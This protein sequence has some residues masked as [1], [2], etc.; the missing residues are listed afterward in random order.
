MPWRVDDRVRTIV[1]R[2]LADERVRWSSFLH[3][4]PLGSRHLAQACYGAKN[5]WD[6]VGFV[7]EIC[8]SQEGCAHH[9]TLLRCQLSNKS[10]LQLIQALWELD[11]PPYN[12]PLR[13]AITTVMRAD[14]REVL[15]AEE[16]AATRARDAE[17]APNPG[18]PRSSSS[19]RP[20][21]ISTS[22]TRSASRDGGPVGR[23]V[24]PTCQVIAYIYVPGHHNPLVVRAVGTPR[25]PV[26]EFVFGQPA[27][28]E[29]LG[30]DPK[31]RAK[32]KYLVWN[33]SI[34]GWASHP[35]PHQSLFLIPGERVLYKEEYVS[36]LPQLDY[37][38][39]QLLPTDRERGDPR[40]GPSI[41]NENTQRDRLATPPPTASLPGT[42][43]RPSE[44]HAL[45]GCPAADG[46]RQNEKVA[47]GSGLPGKLVPARKKA[48]YDPTSVIDL[49]LDESEEDYPEGRSRKVPSP[50][51]TSGTPPSL[52]LSEELPPQEKPL[53][54]GSPAGSS[55]A[56]QIARRTRIIDLTLDDSD[57]GN[58]SAGPQVVIDV[59]DCD[60]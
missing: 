55:S 51:S 60:G 7:L 46:T 16:R 54:C 58:T 23:P 10:R 52:S 25:D 49:T 31:S 44:L 13:R 53:G 48:R 56:R 3:P 9:K 34:D 8:L 29:A 19:V 26:V 36:F 37:Y 50:P 6:S 45:L 32:P 1:K 18:T 40:Y 47:A 39:S 5:N 27:I 21:T 2:A 43:P 12:D 11:P 28:Y 38:K 14:L 41:S 57:D 20:R 15:E 4:C 30:I 42:P 22:S 33:R 17:R 24:N 59:S 35:K